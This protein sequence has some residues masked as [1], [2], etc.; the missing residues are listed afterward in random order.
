MLLTVAKQREKTCREATDKHG[1]VDFAVGSIEN[2][3]SNKAADR[4]QSI[5]FESGPWMS[6]VHFPP[7]GGF[8]QA[9]LTLSAQDLHLKHMRLS[10]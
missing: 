8:E 9:I 3:H 5:Y 7:L 4:L 10:R 2:N 1:Y 6:L